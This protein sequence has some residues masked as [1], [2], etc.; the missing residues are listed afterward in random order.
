[1]S[2]VFDK[3][4]LPEFESIKDSNEE[5]L[6]SSKPK[7]IPYLFSGSWQWIFTVL[8]AF[9]WIYAAQGMGANSNDANGFG[10]YFWLIGFIPLAQGLYTLIS[11]LLSYPNT[12]YAYSNRRVMMRTGFIGTDFKT[13]DYDKISDIEVTVNF[14]ERIYNVGTVRFFSGRTETK[15]DTTKKLYD[16]W[17]AIE[18][19]YE[20][21]KRVKQTSLDIKTDINYPNALRPDSNPG[22]NT[23][24]EKK[25]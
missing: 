5:I 7:F 20:I 24:Y 25:D 17:I 23:K 6:W 22:Y 12:V 14:I 18:N 15:D 2:T 3:N 1:M 19:P 16:A 10:K 9:I 8:F 21:F 11:K 13:I 4:L